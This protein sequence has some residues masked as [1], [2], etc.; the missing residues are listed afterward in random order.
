MKPLVVFLIIQYLV[1]FDS[2]FSEKMFLYFVDLQS[3]SRDQSLR[4]ASR[5]PLTGQDRKCFSFFA[6]RH[7]FQKSRFFWIW[8]FKPKV[9]K[10]SLFKP[11][12]CSMGDKQTF[13]RVFFSAAI[14]GMQLQKWAASSW[15][16]CRVLLQLWW[17]STPIHLSQG[18]WYMWPSF[19]QTRH[20]S[21]NTL[22]VFR[23]EERW[24]TLNPNKQR[25]SEESSNKPNFELSGQNSTSEIDVAFEILQ[26]NLFANVVLVQGAQRVPLTSHSNQTQKDGIGPPL[27]LGWE[28]WFS[29]FCSPHRNPGSAPSWLSC[30]DIQ[31]KSVDLTWPNIYK[32][33]SSPRTK[34]QLTLAPETPLAMSIPDRKSFRAGL[35]SDKPWQCSPQKIIAN[36][37]TGWCCGFQLSSVYWHESWH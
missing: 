6:F 5:C 13:L 36:R 21:K 29:S 33:L 2:C 25:L 16:V 11:V 23:L 8:L 20:R 30:H 22:Q 3:N 34:D 31:D 12:V 15:W 4:I 27:S 24:V 26:I 37:S 17:E 14:F 35:L 1:V 28:F 9:Q 10:S 7:C 32:A 18:N 19:F